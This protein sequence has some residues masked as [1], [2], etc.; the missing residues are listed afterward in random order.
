MFYY[1]ILT[2]EGDKMPNATISVYLSD[3][4]YFKYTKNKE[5]I[6]AKVRETVKK[7]IENG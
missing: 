4:D 7:I 2:N 5:K 3:E 1:T 6:N